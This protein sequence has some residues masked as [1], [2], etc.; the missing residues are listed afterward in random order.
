MNQRLGEG[1]A[2][3]INLSDLDLKGPT[4]V[5]WGLDSPQLNVNFVT[6]NAGDAVLSH[7]NDRV[8]V[9]LIVVSGRGVVVIDDVEHDVAPDSVTLIPR[10]TSRSIRSDGGMTYYSIHVR[11][12]GLALGP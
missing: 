3:S 10:T 12:H 5:V 8:D 4:G 2:I 9:L 11:S 1:E 6:V 7:V